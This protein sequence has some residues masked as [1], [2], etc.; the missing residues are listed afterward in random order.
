M[1]DVGNTAPNRLAPSM[2]VLTFARARHHAGDAGRACSDER[3]RLGQRADRAL[4]DRVGD[5]DH[6]VGARLRQLAQRAPRPLPRAPSIGGTS[7][8][9][10]PGAR[11]S[12]TKAHALRA[13][14]AG[15]RP[16]SR[17]A[18]SMR[19]LSSANP[20]AVLP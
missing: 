6:L 1:Y 17:A 13:I 2:P 20:S 19:A 9:P 8:R 14:S 18:A 10:L 3:D 11:S 7:V 4:G 12:T 5:E 16:A 15:S